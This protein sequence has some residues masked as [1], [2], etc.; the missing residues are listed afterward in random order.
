MITEV[1]ELQFQPI[2]AHISGTVISSAVTLSPSATHNPDKGDKVLIQALTQNIKF[3]LNGTTPTT[4]A[5]G[6]GFQMK[7]G[8][9]PVI[10]NIKGLTLRVIQEAA[11]AQIEFQ[12]GN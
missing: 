2:G 3:T 12:M 5:S 9:P 1:R 4:A 10:I 8:D 11:T 6:L 7:A